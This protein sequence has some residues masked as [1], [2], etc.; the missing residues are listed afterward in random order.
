[1]VVIAII[2]A[3]V[4][5]LLPAV[6]AAREAARRAKCTNN[7]KQIGIAIHNYES[8]RGSFPTGAINFVYNRPDCSLRETRQHTMF[9]FLLPFLEQQPLHNAINF[10][11][12]PML[13]APHVTAQFVQST[14]FASR[15]E[16]YICPSDLPQGMSVAPSG[17]RYP[18][19]SYAGMAGTINSIEW[20]IGNPSCDDYEGNGVFAPA[21]TYKP[22]DVTDGLSATI[23]AGETSRYQNDL[24]ATVHHW[25]R[26]ANYFS[27]YGPTVGRGNAL[28]TGVP[29][30]NAPIQDPDPAGY[31]PTTNRDPVP[32]WGLFNW[33]HNP[34]LYERGQYGFRSFHP[35]GAEFLFGDGSVKFLKQT[36]NPQVYQALSTRG[37]S[38]V[39]SADAF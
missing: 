31:G 1:L 17:S 28:A 35:G 25:N 37:Q 32:P 12:P 7:L 26:Y 34:E 38:E 29:R 14:A 22:S 4:A 21:F 39:I 20:R 19:G 24:D 33:M 11:L 9:S 27:S 6:Q 8:A 18:Q 30:I 16:V 2:G 5:L 23:F 36:I 15:V 13:I 3:L 10:D